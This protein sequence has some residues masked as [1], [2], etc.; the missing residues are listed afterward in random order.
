MSIY[1]F[2]MHIQIWINGMNI[3]IR[4]ISI[5]SWASSISD[6]YIDVVV[7][8]FSRSAFPPL[9]LSLFSIPVSQFLLLD[10]SWSVDSNTRFVY[11]HQN[12]GYLTDYRG[13]SVRFALRIGSLICLW[14]NC[15]AQ[16]WICVCVCV[17]KM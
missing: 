8:S 7:L 17:D 12:E 1:V 10:H 15:E 16:M 2:N 9:D 14:V 5:K 11:Q 6:T 4:L 13:E 3:S